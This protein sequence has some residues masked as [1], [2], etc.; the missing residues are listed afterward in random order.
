MSYPELAQRLQAVATQ[1]ARHAAALKGPEPARVAAA[2]GTQLSKLE[3]LLA[4]GASHD[5]PEM[6][7]LG[8]LLTEWSAEVPA[9]AWAALA[10]Q[11]ALKLPKTASAAAR[12][13]KF[14]EAVAKSG[15]AAAAVAWFEHFALLKRRPVA[16]LETEEETRAEIRRLGAGTPEQIELELETSFSDAQVRALA[17]AAGL[18]VTPKTTRKKLLPDLVHYLRRHHLNTVGAGR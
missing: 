1:L 18:R 8:D 4:A 6:R 3:K 12:Q 14:L 15:N 13:E 9:N 2:L 5:T 11:L 16:V 17:A 7:R 10:K